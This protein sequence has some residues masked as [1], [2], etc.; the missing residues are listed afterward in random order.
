MLCLFPTCR[1][2]APGLNPPR[3]RP[4]ASRATPCNTLQRFFNPFVPACAAVCLPR[5]VPP[6]KNKPTKPTQKPL[7][8]FKNP[9]FPRPATAFLTK[10]SQLRPWPPPRNTS[11]PNS[12]SSLPSFAVG[13]RNA[14]PHASPMS[15]PLTQ[16]FAEGALIRPSDREGN[17]VHLVRAIYSLCG[18]KD[19]P[20]GPPARQLM[21]VIGPAQN[22]GVHPARWAGDEHDQSIAGRFIS[23]FASARRD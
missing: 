20:L 19:L 5:P 2:R 9:V 8:R 3:E 22:I 16:L 13:G 15:A 6:P 11:N 10:Q 1:T 23:G 12:W 17:L 21:D 14:F 7:P 4:I 18:A